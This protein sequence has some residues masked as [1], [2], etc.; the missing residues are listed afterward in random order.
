MSSTY[1]NLFAHD[2]SLKWKI[3]QIEALK[4]HLNLFISSLLSSSFYFWC[5]CS[6]QFFE[7]FSRKGIFS[8]SQ[9]WRMA[10][11]KAQQ[12][13]SF[14]GPIKPFINFYAA[15]LQWSTIF[16]RLFLS[17][18]EVVLSMCYQ[19]GLKRTSSGQN[20]LWWVEIDS[21]GHKWA[22]MSQNVIKWNKWDQIGTHLTMFG[23]IG[24]IWAYGSLRTNWDQMGPDGPKW[25]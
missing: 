13:V 24:Q 22:Q 17:R 10:S 4:W 25:A 20:G 14:K 5:L 19:K 8:F 21:K 1:S 2:S 9:E 23:Q 15:L 7:F 18:S 3:P 16:L 11:W 6:W 12:L